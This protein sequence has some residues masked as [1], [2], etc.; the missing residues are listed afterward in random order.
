MA[1]LSKQFAAWLERLREALILS[2]ATNDRGSKAELA[3]R[4]GIPPADL[5]RWRKKPEKANLTLDRFEEIARTVRPDLPL[6]LVLA[7]IE[8]SPAYVREPDSRRAEDGEIARLWRRL[9]E[10]PMAATRIIYNLRDAEDLGLTELTTRVNRLIVNMGPHEA[11]THIS[12]L[13]HAYPD[14]L[15]TTRLKRKRREMAKAYEAIGLTRA[16][17][18]KLPDS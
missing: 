6:H 14:E 7:E 15:Q 2:G 11:A 18:E 9:F 13:L 10:N 5:S 17:L 4:T 8:K 3:R 1:M 12:A 16:L